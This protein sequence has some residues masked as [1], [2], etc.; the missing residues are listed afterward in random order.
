MEILRTTHRTWIVIFKSDRDSSARLIKYRRKKKIVWCN[1]LA[2][3]LININECSAYERSNEQMM[4]EMWKERRNN[5]SFKTPSVWCYKM[6]GLAYIRQFSET[7]HK[8][9]QYDVFQQQIIVERQHVNKCN[10][11]KWDHLRNFI[12]SSLSRFFCIILLLFKLDVGPV[13]AFQCLTIG[14]QRTIYTYVCN[15]YMVS[16]FVAHIFFWLFIILHIIIIAGWVC[17]K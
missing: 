2:N 17:G 14:K 5:G 12:C 13:S 15:V 3:E 9:I 1:M 16:S 11:I 6:C 7:Q 4:K 8:C 10:K